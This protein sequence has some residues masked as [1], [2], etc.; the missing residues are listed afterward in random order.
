MKL[1][2]AMSVFAVALIPLLGAVA[3]GCAG[4]ESPT[5]Q[6]ENITQLSNYEVDIAAA[7]ELWTP[8]VPFEQPADIWTALVRVGEQTIPAPTHLFGDVINII[9]YSNDDGVADAAGK[10]FERGDQEIAKV[11]KPGQI[12]I[13][14]KNHRPEKHVVD[15]NEA[16]AANMKEDFKLQDTHIEL[17]V[18]VEEAEHGMPGAITLNNPQNYE[19]GAFGNAIYSMIFFRPMLPEYAAASEAE[20]TANSLLALVGFNATTN[21]PGDYNGGDPLGAKNPEKLGIYVDQMV[22]A[23]AGDTDAKEWFQTDENQVYCAELAFVALNA[24]ILTPLNRT[25]MEPRV[26]AEVWASFVEQVE[27]HNRGVDEFQET[28][29]ISEENT[30]NFLA[31]NENKRA[32]MIRLPEIS[33]DLRPVAD[34]NPADAGKMAFQAMTMSDIVREFMRTHIPREKLGEPLAP[35]QGA[36]LAKMKPGLFEAMKMDDMPDTD[37]RKIAVSQLFDQIVEVVSTQFA[38][39]EEF[40]KNIEPFMQKAREITGPRPGDEIGEGLF[41]PP[42]L[43]HSVAQGHQAGGIMGMQYEG[44][45]VHVTAVRA[46][47]S[48]EPAPEPTPVDEIASEVS[49]AWRASD[50]T[51]DVNSCGGQAPGGCWCDSFCTEAGDCCN[52]VSAVC[53]N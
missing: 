5:E 52:D 51:T 3:Q 48:D 14:L 32:G 22:R 8:A 50:Q 18:G 33:D 6:S 10:V 1:R 24:G 20:Y 45:G 26:G 28:G 23:I 42:S 16:D 7:N 53:G 30:S 19:N 4:D 49:C 2:R 13:A 12:G 25:F 11:F 37:P 43:Y 36:I 17:V 39:Y 41:V 15:L 21:F 47:S 29:S 9:P 44:H 35:V 31:F 34:L 46:K 38:S 40:Q 27:I